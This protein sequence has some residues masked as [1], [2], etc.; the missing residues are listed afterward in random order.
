MNYLIPVNA[1]ISSFDLLRTR[2]FSTNQLLQSLKK[3]A[4]KQNIII[5]DVC[6]NGTYTSYF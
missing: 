2:A 6:R 3:S 1:G 5:L 4:S